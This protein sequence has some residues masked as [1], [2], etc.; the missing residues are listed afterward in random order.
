MFYRIFHEPIGLREMRTACDVLKIPFVGKLFKFSTGKLWAIVGQQP[1]G[2]TINSK[3]LLHL[4][5]N[6]PSRRVLEGIHFKPARVQV[7]KHKVLHPTSIKI[8]CAH[9][10][11]WK[12][13]DRMDQ[14]SLFLLVRFS[15]VAWLAQ[16][17]C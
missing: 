13:W 16:N 11:L 2:N 17:Y 3:L 14:E 1:K 12:I 9:E 6:S 8:V 7:D 10:R 15:A 5:N 4:L